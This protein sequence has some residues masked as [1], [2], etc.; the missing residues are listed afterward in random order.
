VT[1][2]RSLCKER[3]INR[4][5]SLAVTATSNNNDMGN[6]T[7]EN[8]LSI[9]NNSVET[10]SLKEE[11]L[12]QVKQLSDKLLNF[13][14][15]QLQGDNIVLTLPSDVEKRRSSQVSTDIASSAQ[16]SK[17][18]SQL[19]RGVRMLP[20]VTFKTVSVAPALAGN[21]GTG[22]DKTSPATGMRRLSNKELIS[23]ATKPAMQVCEVKSQLPVMIRIV[24]V[25][26]TQMYS[27]VSL[28]AN[29]IDVSGEFTHTAPIS[30][31]LPSLGL[32]DREAAEQ[33][34]LNVVDKFSIE[35]KLGLLTLKISE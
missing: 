10:K 19:F 17:E 27:A 29:I 32:V 33:F 1:T 14:K 8:S 9:N 16:G 6:L 13:V 12:R 2:I 5:V 7:R 28:V 3:V 31:R 4:R 34:A 20:M 18:L 22:V 21:S 24:S 15:I 35:C 23:A 26:D 25:E 11:S 30:V